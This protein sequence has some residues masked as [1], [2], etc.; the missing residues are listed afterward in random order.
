M[1]PRE[2]SAFLLL[3]EK[4]FVKRRALRAQLSK[5]LAFSRGSRK[6]LA[7][8]SLPKLVGLAALSSLFGK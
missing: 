7:S 5:W 3:H 6:S 8:V 4:D 1:L 2:L